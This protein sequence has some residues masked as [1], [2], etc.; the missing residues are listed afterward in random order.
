MWYNGRMDDTSTP[1][2]ASPRTKILANGAVYDLDKGRIVANPGG[3]RAAI[4]K[5][6]SS[7]YHA[8]RQ[9]K[10]R[11]LIARVASEAVERG[12]FRARY[13]DMA[14]VAA[15]AETALMKATTPDDPKAVDAARFLLQETGLAEPRQAAGA[16]ASVQAEQ[17][18]VLQVIGAEAAAEILA[19]MR[20]NAR[21]NNNYQ[22]HADGE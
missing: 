3:G 14:F 9:Q 4:T 13:G 20:G 19:A 18:V 15:I 7:A 10:K 16:P 21:D 6:T 12:D 1:A 17:A 5:E 11:A 2:T 8:R 22:K